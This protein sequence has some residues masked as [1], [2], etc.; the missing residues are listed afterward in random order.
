M[1][2]G[3]IERALSADVFARTFFW[4]LRRRSRMSQLVLDIMAKQWSKQREEENKN[5]AQEETSLTYFNK[6]RYNRKNSD[7]VLARGFTS[8]NKVD[9]ACAVMLTIFSPL[10]NARFKRE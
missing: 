3:A 6:I 7:G 1:D 2:N 8:T 9:S 10:H 4:Q 5:V